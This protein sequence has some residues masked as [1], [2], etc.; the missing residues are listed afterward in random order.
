MT[1]KKA[2]PEDQESLTL[3]PLPKKADGESSERVCQVIKKGSKKM[4]TSLSPLGSKYTKKAP[5]SFVGIVKTL[6][7]YAN[8][9]KEKK[10]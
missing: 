4:T 1:A 5:K 10:K 2:T 9:R 7:N 3:S 6:K 8:P